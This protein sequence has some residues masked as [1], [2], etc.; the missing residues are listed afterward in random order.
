MNAL[1]KLSDACLGRILLHASCLAKCYVQNV[2]SKRARASFHWCGV[3]RELRHRSAVP[4]GF[5]ASR[6]VQ[7]PND[8]SLN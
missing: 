6:A 3:K 7:N 1:L 2:P 5:P 8:F 4:P